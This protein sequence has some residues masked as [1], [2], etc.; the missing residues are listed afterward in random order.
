MA[1]RSA[2]AASVRAASSATVA[3][4]TV[5]T[6]A[7]ALPPGVAFGFA[8]ADGAAAEEEDDDEE[9]EAVGRSLSRSAG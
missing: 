4:R 7:L 9:D 8:V 2:P 6:H 1:W 3:P 5:R